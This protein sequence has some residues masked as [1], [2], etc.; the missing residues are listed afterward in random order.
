MLYSLQA[1]I[2]IKLKIYIVQV[3]DTIGIM[4]E[5]YILI[6]LVKKMILE[7]TE[8]FLQFQVMNVIHGRILNSGMNMMIVIGK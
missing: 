3:Q 7:E 6:Y 2:K 4:M 8:M 5:I 1:V